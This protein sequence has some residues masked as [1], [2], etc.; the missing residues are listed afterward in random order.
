MKAWVRVCIPPGD[1]VIQLMEPGLNYEVALIT[2]YLVSS[3][4]TIGLQVAIGHVAEEPKGDD[5]LLDGRSVTMVGRESPDGIFVEPMVW[6][7]PTWDLSF[8]PSDRTLADI[9]QDVVDHTAKFPSH[10]ACC[11][12]MDEYSR[13]VRQHIGKAMPP[14]SRPLGDPWPGQSDPVIRA[15]VMAHQRIAHVLGMVTRNF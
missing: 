10:G 12:C 13:E 2:P 4:Q 5:H 15:R 3:Y 14:D 9:M 1:P 7:D 6:A 11:S 8:I